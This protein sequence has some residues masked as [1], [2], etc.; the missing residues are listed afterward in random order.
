MENTE[1]LL[2]ISDMMDEKLDSINVRMDIMEDKLTS[3][4]DAV[5][6][7]LSAEIQAVDAK[8]SAEIQAMDAKLDATDERLRSQ[9]R[10]ISLTQEN[11]I[12]PRL[13]HI[14]Q[15][16]LSTSERYLIDSGR[17]NGLVFDMQVVKSVLQNHEEK[18][19]KI[20]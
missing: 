10:K 11:I 15:C 7:K 13:E 3:K 18:L 6:A 5:D 20:S 19:K 8:L 9:I 2:A 1:L 16:Y 17:I 12:I 4:I 14:E